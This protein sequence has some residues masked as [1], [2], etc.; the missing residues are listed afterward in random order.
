MAARLRQQR[1][2]RRPEVE[3]GRVD[4]DDGRIAAGRGGDHVPRVLL[5]AGRVGD[6][7]LALARREIAVGDVDRD[8][9][10]ALGLEAVGEE[11][12]VDR[13]R[14]AAPSLEGVELVGEDGA[15]VEQQPADQRALAVVDAARG[16][17]A[18]R[19]ARA[20]RRAVVAQRE[21]HQK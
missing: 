17:E 14:R 12:E 11:G 2:R 13:L 19:P 3:L 21:S 10:L 4:E 7:E 15:A 5:V 8:A 9:L 18:K 1:H 20:R 6:D 16:E